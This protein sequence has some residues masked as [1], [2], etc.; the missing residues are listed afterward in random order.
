MP[1]RALLIPLTDEARH[2]LQGRD[3]V[4]IDRLPFR[5]GRESR[6]AMVEGELAF[7]E[8]R[9]GN[10]P[11]NN[12]LYLVDNGERLNISREHMQIEADPGDGFLVHD[13][14]SACGTMVDGV[15]IGGMDRTGSVPLR[16]G[17]EVVIGTARSPYRFR[18]ENLAALSAPNP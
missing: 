16:E 9:K 15:A 18:V 13:R 1:D 5:I 12:D 4:E 2:A 11:P 10:K 17:S 7:M 3:H 6:L 8:R 14:G